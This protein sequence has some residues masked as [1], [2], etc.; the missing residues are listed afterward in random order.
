MISRQ[1][2]SCEYAAGKWVAFIKGI[3]SIWEFPEYAQAKGY[4]QLFGSLV[5]GTRAESATR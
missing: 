3:G 4:A 2:R 5:E 1:V